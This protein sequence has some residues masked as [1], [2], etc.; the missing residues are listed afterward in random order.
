M[1][2][3][4]ATPPGSY[5]APEGLAP[6]APGLRP[7]TAQDGTE[8]PFAALL[9]ALMAAG[10]VPPPDSAPAMSAHGEGSEVSLAGPGGE[11]GGGDLPDAAYGPTPEAFSVGSQTGELPASPMAVNDGSAPPGFILAASNRPAAPAMDPQAQSMVTGTGSEPVSEAI[12]SAGG[13][14]PWEAFDPVPG[15]ADPRLAGATRSPTPPPTSA[16]PTAVAAEGKEPL[17]P[18]AASSTANTGATTPPANT[19]EVAEGMRVAAP[20]TAGGGDG[21]LPEGERRDGTS[22]P[23]VEGGDGPAPVAE[24]AD[25]MPR[26]GATARTPAPQLPPRAQPAAIPLLLARTLAEGGRSLR[27][28]LDP[29]ALGQL[30]VAVRT[31]PGGRLR[32]TIRVQRP[33]ALERLRELEVELG[34]VLRRD[35][36]GA[37]V[38]LR[39]V[40][41][42]ERQGDE[43][44]SRDPNP[45]A[46]ARRPNA[47]GFDA[48]LAGLLDVRI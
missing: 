41:A 33:E 25:V 31:A 42:D 3:L 18:T 38:E 7:I 17:M 32:A 15:P 16:V 43:P 24:G 8:S 39:F 46:P 9:A 19:A 6:A 45:V 11:A 29:P 44:E 1:D 27:I 22:M 13:D 21:A 34:R 35:E 47:R 4:P 5:P 40:L 14:L 28:Q 37:P 10:L 48:L 36:G 30:E 23:P 2:T 26:D 20:S 12:R